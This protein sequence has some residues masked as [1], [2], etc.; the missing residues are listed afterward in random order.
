MVD[1]PNDFPYPVT[2]LIITSS[3]TPPLS[4]KYQ[5][6]LDMLLSSLIINLAVVVEDR[7]TRLG[8]LSHVQ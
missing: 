5:V 8:F 4:V 7:T 1:W 6:T 3:N 2:V